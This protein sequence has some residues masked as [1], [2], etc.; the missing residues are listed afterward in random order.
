MGKEGEDGEKATSLLE[1][2]VKIMG[3]KEGARSGYRKAYRITK[4]GR[5]KVSKDT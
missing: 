2:V 5:R 4:K 3:N 1:L